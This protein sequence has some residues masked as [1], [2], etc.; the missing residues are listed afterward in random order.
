MLSNL[1]DGP[2]QIR[3]K[4]RHKLQVWVIMLCLG[5]GWSV[6][7]NLKV[8]KLLILRECACASSACCH[9]DILIGHLLH[10]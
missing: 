4:S 1:S 5:G 8:N 6:T 7:S 3:L 2:T 10:M 9:R